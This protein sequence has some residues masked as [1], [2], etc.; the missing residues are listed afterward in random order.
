MFKL[1]FFVYLEISSLTSLSME[2]CSLFLWYFLQMPMLFFI[3]LF[4]MNWHVEFIYREIL[5]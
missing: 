4:T 3:A 2:I 1:I 5:F